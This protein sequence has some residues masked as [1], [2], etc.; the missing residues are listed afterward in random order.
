MGARM[1]SDRIAFEKPLSMAEKEEF[2]AMMIMW[3]MVGMG[4]GA[5][6]AM[7]LRWFGKS[8]QDLVIAEM[9]HLAARME[10]AVFAL[11][12]KVK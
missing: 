6:I 10:Q 1:G 5:G 11:R 7:L 3:F 9:Q 4:T 8:E 12:E 2:K